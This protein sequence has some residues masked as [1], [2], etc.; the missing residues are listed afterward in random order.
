VPGVVLEVPLGVVCVPVDVVPVVVPDDDVPGAPVDPAPPPVTWAEAIPIARNNT[1]DVRKC[2]CM[3]S[4]L[5]SHRSDDRQ[6]C[7]KNMAI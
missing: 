5:N 7:S 2:F 3:E 1:E 4:P 6:R